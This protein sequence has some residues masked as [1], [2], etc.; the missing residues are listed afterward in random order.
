MKNTRYPRLFERIYGRPLM[1]QP[2]KAFVIERVFHT[3]HDAPFAMLRN[4]AFSSDVPA[5]DSEEPMCVVTDSGI[6][7][8]SVMGTL[9]QRSSWLD[10]MSGLTSYA[11]I[12]FEFAQAEAD[13]KVRGILLEIDSG[14]G[15][16][17]GCFDLVD[18]IAACTK[19]V[20]AVANESA[21]SAAYAIAS[22]AD[23]I[24]MPRTA[25]VGS[26]GV[27]ALHVDQSQR[28]QKTGYTYTAVYAGSHKNDYTSHAPLADDQ[29]IALQGEI[30]RMYQMFVDTVATNRGISADAVRATQAALFHPQAAIDVGLADDIG[31]LDDVI[32]E[33]EQFLANPT[34]MRTAAPA[35]LVG[36]STAVPAALSLEP[37]MDPKNMAATPASITPEALAQGRAEAEA[38]G[39]T[40]GEQAGLAL[41][42]K[43]E[44]TRIGA[45]LECEEAQGRTETARALAFDSDMSVEAVRIVL[46]KSSKTA[47]PAASATPFARAMADVPNPKVHPDGGDAGEEGAGERVSEINATIQRIANAG[48]PKAVA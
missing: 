18:Q 9:V 2:E 30:D 35:G 32:N 48:K 11:K 12:G 33:F 3:N 26:I 40:A 22:A 6:A 45:I 5:D 19:P 8:M 46:G 10:A 21:Y 38:A 43:Q 36:I 14:G 20:W 47:A 39:R 44:R 37:G 13:P 1:L 34:G 23:R 4:Q 31:T 24:V 16:V 27:I 42:A 15:E 7:I 25:G 29:R 17:N 28:D 41:G